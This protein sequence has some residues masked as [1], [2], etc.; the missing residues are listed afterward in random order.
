MR[1]YLLITGEEERKT[2]SYSF[3]EQVNYSE[4]FIKDIG[5]YG[6]G[7]V[8][9]NRSNKMIIEKGRIE[10]L[11]YY[12]EEHSYKVLFDDRQSLEKEVAI[13]LKE[14]DCIIPLNKG[15]LKKIGVFL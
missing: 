12:K 4:R 2:D 6:V 15:D 10:K 1:S 14:N 7:Y 9:Y 5:L 8:L 3:G 11:N 13:E